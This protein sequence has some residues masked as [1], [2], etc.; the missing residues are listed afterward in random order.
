MAF[1]TD[2]GLTTRPR[3]RTW[4]F[5]GAIGL[6]AAM[7]GSLLPQVMPG[8]VP[9]NVAA[10]ASETPSKTPGQKADRTYKPPTWPETPSSAAMLTRLA[11]GTLV[12]LVLCVGTLL[13]GKRWLVGIAPPKATAEP[14][15]LRIVEALP[16]G[17]RCAL[18]LVQAGNRQILIGVDAL[19]MKAVVPLGE[20]F[21]SE[22]DTLAGQTVFPQAEIDDAGHG[23]MGL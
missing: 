18:H 1:L 7:A 10:P 21:E 22:F 4:L 14:R 11:I 19:G 20:T 8:P 23:P 6:L 16:L 3:S 12:V 15:Q 5:I 2:H 9:E 17:N 13:V